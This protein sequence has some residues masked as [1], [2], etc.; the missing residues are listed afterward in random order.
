M[1]AVQDSFD[2]DFE[3]KWRSL[4]EGCASA[5][6]GQS[7]EWARTLQMV[8]GVT[9]WTLCADTPDTSD[10]LSLLLNKS[11]LK[12]R[13]AVSSPMTS[14]GG[15][16]LEPQFSSASDAI[17]EVVETRMTS[18]R[19]DFVQLNMDRPIQRPKWHAYSHFSS[20][21]LSL[22]DGEEAIWTQNLRDKTRNQVRKAQKQNFTL[23]VEERC[24]SDFFQTLH[25]GVK[26]LGSPSPN[27]MLFDTMA[28]NFASRIAFL[29][30]YD[31]ATPVSASIALWDKGTLSNP[32]CRRCGPGVHGC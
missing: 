12:G 13:Y 28:E 4:Y 1:I 15:A 16:F 26:E 20:F 10:C 17:L 14:S 11:V 7:V 18:H 29:T 31:S 22:S 5:P 6:Y 25:R 27:R 30:L 8:F 9:P 23:R 2:E 3:A 21:S 24:S 19:L 32:R